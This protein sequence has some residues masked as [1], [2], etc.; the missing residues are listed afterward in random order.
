[1]HTQLNRPHR[2]KRNDPLLQIIRIRWCNTL[3]NVSNDL[4]Y[5][6]VPTEDG[7]QQ[8]VT[9]TH[10]LKGSSTFMSTHAP[11]RPILS[12]PLQV[13]QATHKQPKSHKQE[14]SIHNPNS[15]T[16]ATNNQNKAIT[17]KI[18]QTLQKPQHTFVDAIS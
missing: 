18:R 15:S 1:M 11:S 17:K 14:S 7:S 3:T 6:S 5:F 13:V 4:T 12:Y 10:A 2:N 8:S 9:F 16:K